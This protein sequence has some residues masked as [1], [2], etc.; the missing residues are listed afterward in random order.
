MSAVCRCVGHFMLLQEVGCMM[1]PVKVENIGTAKKAR[2]E[3][4]L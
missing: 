3:T 2:G 4:P 1:A